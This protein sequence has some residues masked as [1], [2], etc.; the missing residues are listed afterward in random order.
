M[1]QPMLIQISIKKITGV[2]SL[3]IYKILNISVLIN[4]ELLLFKTLIDN[5]TR[6]RE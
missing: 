6:A 1:N 2:K 5:K 3:L 4:L